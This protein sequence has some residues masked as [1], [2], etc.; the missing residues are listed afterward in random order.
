MLAAV[1]GVCALAG[2]GTAAAKPLHINLSHRFAGPPTTQQCIEQ[3]GIP[4]YQ[5]HQ[6]WQAYDMKS[7]F[8][9]GINGAGKTIVIVDS[10]GSP[11]IQSDI[12]TFD[13]AFKLPPAHVSVIQPAGPVPAWDPGNSTM[14][15]WAEETSLDVEMAHTMAPGAKILLVEAPVAETEGVTGFP[16]MMQAENYVINHH[17]GDVISQ[18]F[19]ATEQTFPSFAALQELRY[20]FKNAAAHGVTVLGSSGDAGVSGFQLDGVH[21]YPFRVNSWPSADPLVTSLGGTQLHLDHEGNRLAPDNVWN[22][23]ALFGSP[24]AGGGGLS[25]FFSKPAYQRSVEGVVGSH[26][27]TPDISMSAAV[28]GAAL[29][30]LGFPGI[31]PGWYLF[32]GTSEAS[33]LFSGIVADAAQAA[34]HDLGLLGPSLYG[35]GAS[36]APGVVDVTAGDNTV[37]VPKDKATVVVPG[38]PAG[39]GYD[40]SSGLGTADGAQ[41]VHE[42]AGH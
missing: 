18:S 25:E 10:F 32:G 31:T 39:P 30:Y 12:K 17:M 19:G 28:N 21:Y 11:T 23:S 8:K 24:A 2:A 7:L 38:Y 3:A 40:M 4:C 5:P 34:G 14:V 26:R 35:L 41:L 22:D 9:S 29:V 13:E 15:G 6:F 33:P 37:A 20:A 1:A 42:L 27:G 36:H 16:Q